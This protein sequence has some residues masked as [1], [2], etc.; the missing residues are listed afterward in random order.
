MLVDTYIWDVNELVHFHVLAQ[1]RIYFK[2]HEIYSCETG[3][4]VIKVSYLSK[5]R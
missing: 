4:V 2:V 3:S 1:V 5:L